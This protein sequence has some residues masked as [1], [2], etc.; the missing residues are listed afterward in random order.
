[1]YR[2]SALG[3]GIRLLPFA[4]L[5]PI[6]TGVSAAIAGKAKI[7]PVYLLPAGAIIQIIG[8]TLLSTESTGTSPGKAQYG[9]QAIAGF[10]VGMNLGTLILMTPF[11]VEKRDKCL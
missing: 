3:A 11:A 7:P 1:M 9:Y 8:F 6:G 2:I 4:V 10:G 5:S